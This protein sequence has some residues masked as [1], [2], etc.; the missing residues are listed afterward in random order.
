MNK[1]VFQS[2]K[3][4]ILLT[5]KMLDSVRKSNKTRFLPLH[6]KERSELLKQEKDSVFCLQ[7]GTRWQ[8]KFMG[9]M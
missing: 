9:E 3:R 1:I 5:D 4:K 2:Y 8:N 7:N 6:F